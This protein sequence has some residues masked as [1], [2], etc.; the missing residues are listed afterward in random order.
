MAS[1]DMLGGRI[2]GEGVDG[3][4][5]TNP[6]WPCIAESH[7][8]P[9][10]TDSKY[11]SKIVLKSDNE[12]EYLRIASR[13]LGPVL[14]SKY[15]AGIAG[16]CNPANSSSLPAPKDMEALKISESSVQKWPRKK[17]TCDVISKKIKNRI[18]L[19]KNSKIMIISRYTMSVDKW[20][21]KVQVENIPYTE[22][23]K[24][25]ESAI[26]PFIDILQKL[27]QDPS[28][29]LIHIDL[30]T[31]NIFVKFNPFVFGIADFGNC[32]FRRYN[33]DSSKIFFGKY[34]ID[35][36]TNFEF[37]N[38]QFSQVPL[39]SR[40]LNYCFKK[41]LENVTPLALVR[42]WENDDSVRIYAANSN[43]FVGVKRSV[44]L[45]YLLQKVLFIAM[46]E[47]IQSIC[48]KLRMFSDNS[49][50]LYNS[51]T[52]LEKT[53]IDFILTRYS[54]LSPINT[55]LQE[56]MK[57]YPNVPLN[58]RIVRFLIEGIYTPYNQSGSSLASALTS[59]KS[60]D[61]N[62]LWKKVI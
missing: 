2:I 57:I 43:D 45:N 1:L 29:E 13:I 46:I 50:N 10:P 61:F 39:E 56:I 19:S 16:E 22:C 44:L 18:P 32:V 30:H 27:Y 7:D 60:T 53:A 36:I 38:G 51:L 9:D 3:C 8:V 54:I 4:I 17:G 6:M 48:K 42:K 34:L 25:I 20:F 40:I 21:K 35:Y 31:G 12:S 28:E 11:V 62:I 33:E 24:M 14:S 26:P 23:I 55:I 15:I 58:S 59:V 47:C 52:S 5:L 37:Y 41:Q 49:T